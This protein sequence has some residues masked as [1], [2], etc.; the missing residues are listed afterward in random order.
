MNLFT[1]TWLSMRGRRTNVIFTIIAIM[2]AV[3]LTITVLMIS[4]SL[5]KGI[6]K[7]AGSYDQIREHLLRKPVR[8]GR[9]D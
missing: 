1:Y 8:T 9:T 5:E 4:K 3:A 6:K 2:I 7:Q